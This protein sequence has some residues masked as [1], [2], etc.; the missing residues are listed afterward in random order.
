MAR[1]KEV[2]SEEALRTYPVVRSINIGCPA[3]TRKV[4]RHPTQPLPIYLVNIIFANVSSFQ[5]QQG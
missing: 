5:P 4:S 2:L 1:I 3:R